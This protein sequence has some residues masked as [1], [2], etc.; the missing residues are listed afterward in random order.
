MDYGGII[1]A[2]NISNFCE[3]VQTITI[4]M[5]LDQKDI[6]LNLINLI[7]HIKLSNLMNQIYRINPMSIFMQPIYFLYE[8]RTRT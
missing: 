4:T 6:K 2:L 3:Y 8:K 5:F 1:A 7:Y